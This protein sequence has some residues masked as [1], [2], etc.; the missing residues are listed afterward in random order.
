M[1]GIVG[2]FLIPEINVRFAGQPFEIGYALGDA[3]R[4]RIQRA[5]RELPHYDSL[6]VQQP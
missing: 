2:S 1:T 3:L 6:R 4:D 5:L